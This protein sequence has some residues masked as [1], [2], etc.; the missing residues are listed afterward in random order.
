MFSL[1]IYYIF[2]F[3]LLAVS[4]WQYAQ[5]NIG[6]ACFWLLAFGIVVI[7]HDIRSNARLEN[8]YKDCYFYQL[9]TPGHNLPAST[10]DAK[11]EKN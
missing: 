1:A 8:N 10:M 7:R 4:M 3:M 11:D 6:I 2:V 5:K 9:P